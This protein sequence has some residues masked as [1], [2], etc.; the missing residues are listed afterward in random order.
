MSIIRGSVESKEVP[1]G[2]FDVQV[3]NSRL[4]LIKRY[5]LKVDEV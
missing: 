4:L 1:N 3:V 2:T 5:Y